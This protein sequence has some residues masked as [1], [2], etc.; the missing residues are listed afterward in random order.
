MA[1]S[2]SIDYNLTR[3]DIVNQ[4]LEM[5]NIIAAGE[6]P[7]AED[8]QLARN[9]LNGMVKNW[10]A[11][12]LHLWSTDEGVLFFTDETSEYGLISSSTDVYFTTKNDSVITQLG[13]DEASG[14]TVITVDS[15]TGMT[16]ADIVGIVQDDDVIHWSTIASV[17]SS[18]Q[19]TI[20]DA[21]VGAA[22]E[23]GNVYTFTS[24]AN[25]P[26]RILSARLVRGSGTTLNEIPLTQLSK[27]D[28]F[29]I[30]NKNAIGTPNSFYYDPQ[31][32]TGRLY[33]WPA[34]EDPQWYLRYTY[35]RTLEDFD[36]ASDEPDFPQEWLDALVY[37]LAARL[38]P[39][40]GRATD[41]NY[42]MIVKMAEQFRIEALNW[43]SEV[44]EIQFD[45]DD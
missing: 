14:Q 45:I 8:S 18:T 1:T 26:L 5:L 2:G 38:G 33:L 43:D 13:G 28:Y 44:T 42:Q 4:A 23:D 9:R 10:Q 11:Q 31:L 7:S 34:P 6:T 21:T 40:Y 20:D 41:A 36:A 16:A 25:R 39:A 12:G 30:P 27:Q 24:R 17:D 3:N 22:S 15:S 35:E 19:I 37:G 29:N 32:G